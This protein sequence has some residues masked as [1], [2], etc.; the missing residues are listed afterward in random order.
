MVRLNSNPPKHKPVKAQTADVRQSTP[1]DDAA[2]AFVTAM[3][4]RA[5]DTAMGGYPMWF[6]WALYDAFIAGIEHG[7]KR[8]R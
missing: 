2:F 3:V 6:G 4:P 1:D 7:R 5:D 8:V